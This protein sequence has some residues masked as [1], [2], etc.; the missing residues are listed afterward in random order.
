MTPSGNEVTAVASPVTVTPGPLVNNGSSFQTDFNA[1]RTTSSLSRSME[2]APLS[3][4]DS[5]KS[6]LLDFTEQIRRLEIEGIKL[7]AA[8]FSN[9]GKDPFLK[10]TP[11][12]SVP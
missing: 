1:A 8:T 4:R 12:R 3:A 11:E 10:W 5:R 2:S 9:L 6:S 7:R